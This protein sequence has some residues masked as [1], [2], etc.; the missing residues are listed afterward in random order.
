MS[1][2]ANYYIGEIDRIAKESD[3]SWEYLF[4]KFFNEFEC[5]MDIEKFEQM[6]REHAL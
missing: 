5:T 3:Y 2:I 4:E 1:R 6:A